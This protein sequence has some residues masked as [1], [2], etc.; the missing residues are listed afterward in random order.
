VAFSV[1]IVIHAADEPGILVLIQKAVEPK[2]VSVREFVVQR[3]DPVSKEIYVN[4]LL[5]DS[6]LT[7]TIIRRIEGVRGAAV[8]AATEPRPVPPAGK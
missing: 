3:K 5:E 6:N 1:K 2:G 4:L 7:G 8:M